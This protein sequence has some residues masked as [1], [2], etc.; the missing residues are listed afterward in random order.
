MTPILEGILLF[1]VSYFVSYSIVEALS[2]ARS[3]KIKYYKLEVSDE[4]FEPRNQKV[5]TRMTSKRFMVA[6][7]SND[8][9]DLD[10]SP[11]ANRL[12]NDQRLLRM[13]HMAVGMSGE[14]GEVIDLLKKTM[15]YDKPL[16]EFKLKSEIGDV[17]WYMANMLDAL[18]SSFEE[19][20]QMNVD[21]LAK[22]YQ[23]GFTEA[24]AINRRDVAND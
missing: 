14:T 20:M 5:P 3:P 23:N 10:Y 22:R 8:M 11:V 19:V 7:R 12:A 4:C 13:V 15:M 17:L 21:K 24:E 9:P 18:G 16:D 2:F 6:S 1:S